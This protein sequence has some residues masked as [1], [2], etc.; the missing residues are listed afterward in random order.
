MDTLTNNIFL[1]T[2]PKPT[3]LIIYKIKI[4]QKSHYKADRSAAVI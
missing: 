4:S 1:N 2:K 3:A